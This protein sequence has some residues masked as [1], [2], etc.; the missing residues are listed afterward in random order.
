MSI[1]EQRGMC[2]IIT[3]CDVWS[4]FRKIIVKEEA[5]DQLQEA[6]LWRAFIWRHLK[7]NDM[8]EE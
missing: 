1:F 8:T 7:K 4:C 2:V 6:Y 5:Y 3:A